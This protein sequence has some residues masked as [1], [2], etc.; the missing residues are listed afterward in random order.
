MMRTSLIVLVAL[1]ALAGCAK[2]QDT[3]KAPLTEHQRDSVLAGERLPGV[4]AVGEALEESDRQAAN[5]RSTNAMV[6]SLP[7]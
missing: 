1:L 3:A 2:T 5:A 4:G 7:R 6:D